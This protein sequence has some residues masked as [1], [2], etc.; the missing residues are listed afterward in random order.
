MSRLDALFTRSAFLAFFSLLS[1][2]YV[3]LKMRLSR[4]RPRVEVMEPAPALRTLETSRDPEELAQALEEVARTRDRNAVDALGKLLAH[5]EPR[6]SAAAANVLGQIGDER[7]LAYLFE[8]VGRL[9]SELSQMGGEPP[10][11]DEPSPQDISTEP[12]ESNPMVWPDRTQGKRLLE[13]HAKPGDAALG[14]VLSLVALAADR[15]APPDYRYFA[16]KNLELILPTSPVLSPLSP[17]PQQGP[18]AEALARDLAMLLYDPSPSLRYAAVS[19]LEVLRTPAVAQYLEG[20]IMDGNRHV[21]T[22]AC[23]ALASVAPKRARKHLFSLLSDADE[24]VRKAAQ[25]ALEEI[26]A[27]A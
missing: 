22:R 16:L 18:T 2:V 1:A 4:P 10:P 23:M 15:E 6:I 17:S 13:A 8:S 11:A 25:R 20:A 7:A 3:V 24:Q 19:V 27:Q 21:R 5:P 9:E 12:E 14:L 26:D